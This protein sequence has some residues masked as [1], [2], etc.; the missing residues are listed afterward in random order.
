MITVTDEGVL[1]FW[2]ICQVLRPDLSW[3]EY[4]RMWEEYEEMKRVLTHH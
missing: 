1:E 3:E 2:D 4:E